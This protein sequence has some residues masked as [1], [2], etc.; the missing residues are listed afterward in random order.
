[1]LR[2]DNARFQLFGDTMNVAARMEHTGAKNRIQV[3]Q[4]TADLLVKA[5]KGQWVR[6]RSEKVNAKGKGFMQTHWLDIQAAG[7]KRSSEGETNS[8]NS[9]SNIDN[10]FVAGGSKSNAE[11]ND[12]LNDRKQRLVD[13]NVDILSKALKQVVARRQA[14]NEQ[15]DSFLHMETLEQGTLRLYQSKNGAVVP[16]D[17]IVECI[18]LPN[19]NAKAAAVT[20][21]KDASSIDLGPAVQK[22]LHDFIQGISAMYHE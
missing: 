5:G 20:H 21:E 10:N 22:Q 1:V 12:K 15:P 17:E 8:E 14:C 16:L 2:T 11:E 19:Y 3:S 18:S 9:T 4:E 7:S 13:W 6:P